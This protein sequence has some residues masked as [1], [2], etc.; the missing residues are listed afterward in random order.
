MTAEFKVNGDLK[1]FRV[2]FVSNYTYEDLKLDYQ[3]E[4]INEIFCE[5]YH[6]KIIPHQKF[7]DAWKNGKIKVEI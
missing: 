5:E 7:K 2:G 6:N 3:L 1:K 4:C